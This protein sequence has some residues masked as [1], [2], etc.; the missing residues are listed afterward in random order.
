MISTH[1]LSQ[2]INEQSKTDFRNYVNSFRID[3]AKTLL[4]LEPERSIISICFH[5]GF[6]SKAAFN[7]AFKKVVGCSPG[8]FRETCSKQ[9]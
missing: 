1:Q 7:K 2:L 9:L 6:N 8:E 3:E 5:V 4:I